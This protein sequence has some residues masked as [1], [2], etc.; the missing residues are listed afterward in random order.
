MSPAQ[1]AQPALAPRA[2][3]A[4]PPQAPC[5]VINPRSFGTSRHGLAERAAQLARDQGIEVIHAADS[6][7]IAAT[8]DLLLQRRQQIIFLLAGDGTVQA[9]ADRL[10]SLPADVAQPQLLV[11]GGGRTNLT[12][13]ELGGRGNVLSKLETALRRWRD[14]AALDIEIRPV[15]R[16]EQPPAPV[17]HGFFLAAGLVDH[18]IRA[19]HRYRDKGSGALRNGA[20]GTAWTLLKLPLPDMLSMH[21][22]QL[23]DLRVEVP[24]REP[25]AKPAR[26][27]IVS[28]LQHREGLLNP[29]APQGEGAIRFTAIA[30]RNIAFWARLPWIATGRFTPAMDAGRGYLSGRCDA[31]RLQRLSSY[32]LDGE[33]FDA[34]PARPVTI[35]EGPRLTFLTP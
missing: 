30:A 12:A 11:L 13:A 33:E 5:L 23:D 8:M 24:G 29:Y 26:L 31:L 34:D 32:T 9:V 4:L 28:T 20:A 1:P 25:L 14:G 35:R 6:A 27:L 19:C 10:A 7:G 21:D 22:P 3:L 18:A 16:I 2:Q 17:R 15:L